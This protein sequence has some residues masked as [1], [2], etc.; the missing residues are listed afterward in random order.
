MT[1]QIIELES[2]IEVEE[3]TNGRQ[4]VDYAIENE[5]GIS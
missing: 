5:I 1:R 4:A 3:V 2:D